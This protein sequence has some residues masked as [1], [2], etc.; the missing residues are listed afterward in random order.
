M[1]FTPTKSFCF[2]PFQFHK[3]AQY[4]FKESKQKVIDLLNDYFTEEILIIQ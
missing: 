3:G 2:L 1:N 4:Y